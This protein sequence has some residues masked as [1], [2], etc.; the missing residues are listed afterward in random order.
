[1][2]AGESTSP[3]FCS[4]SYRMWWSLTG[5]VGVDDIKSPEMEID[6]KKL[7]TVTLVGGFVSDPFTLQGK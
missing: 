6:G 3:S 4:D 7:P 5:I 1:M 2:E